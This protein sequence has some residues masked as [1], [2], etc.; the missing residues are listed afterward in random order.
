MSA[1]AVC[2]TVTN[3][4]RNDRVFS[5]CKVL[6]SVCGGEAVFHDMYG[7]HVAVNQVDGVYAVDVPDRPVYFRTNGC[8]DVKVGK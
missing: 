3:C 2:H 1:D 4:I 6:V 8:V 7:R 5:K